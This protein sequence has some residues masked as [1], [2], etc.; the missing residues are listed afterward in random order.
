MT[1]SPQT[2]AERWRQWQRE[3]RPTAGARKPLVDYLRDNAQYLVEGA[4][5]LEAKGRPVPEQ[6]VQEL[7]DT[8]ADLMALSTSARKAA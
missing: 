4:L 1:P 2:P 7:R 3:D 5:V 6:D 8:V